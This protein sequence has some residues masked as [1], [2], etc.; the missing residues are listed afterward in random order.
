[1]KPIYSLNKEFVEYLEKYRMWV[2][3]ERTQLFLND[4][5]KIVWQRAP[6][7]ENNRNSHA[8]SIDYLMKI[9]HDLHDGYPQEQLGLNLNYK[10][11]RKHPDKVDAEFIEEIRDVNNQLDDQLQTALGARTCALKMF[12]PK[13]GYIAWHTN[14]NVPGYNIVFTYSATG[15]GHWRHIDPTGSDTFVPNPEKLVH[16]GDVP[17]WH[18]KVG[19]FGAKNETDRLVW[20]SA[21]TDEPR[22][23]VSYVVYDKSIW[24]SMVGE[25]E[26]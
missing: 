10:F 24:D 14:W 4:Q 26:E 20:H 17:G 23:T 19:Y 6:L 12:Y 16:I 1:M 18:C 11:L 13:G 25:L 21:F 9:N 15:N 3:N 2:F 5:N 22:L 7:A 8:T